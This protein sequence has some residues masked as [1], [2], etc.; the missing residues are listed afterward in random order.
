MKAL[1][2]V[3]TG[4]PC[5]GKTTSISTIEQEFTEKNYQV[6]IVPEAA[7]ILINSGIRPFGKNK[8]SMFEFQKYVMNLQKYLEDTAEEFANKS[9]K[10]VIIV[11]DR[12]LMDDKAYVSEDE[13]KELL[14]YFNTT[15]F[16]LMDRYDLVIHLVTAAD[17]KEEFYTTAN[18]GARTETK[19]EAREKDKK[20]L[21]AWLGHDNLKIVGN[22]TDFNTKIAK[23]VKEIYEMIKLPYPINR[24]EKYL[25]KSFD[26]KELLKLKPVILN[27]EQ[28]AEF[29]EVETLYRKTERDGNIKYTRITKIDT[30]KA[31]ERITKRKNI[32]EEEYLIATSNKQHPIKKTRYCFEYCHQYFRLDVF[33]NE[34]TILEIEDTNK[35]SNRKI[36]EFIEVIDNITLDEN[37]RNSNLYIT[38]NL[39][40]KKQEKK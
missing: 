26:I 11:C 12:G 35:S 37:Y 31:E 25:V 27:I 18:N 10:K 30:D 39:P 9:D 28:Y 36:P 29:N 14:D 17:G 34:L 23:S 15:Q 20:T 21:Q 13:F 8:I 4:G 7:T 19:E 1:K 38:K 40:K 32:T 22:E 6:V 5:G 33:D 24:Q 2:V 3:L 16:E